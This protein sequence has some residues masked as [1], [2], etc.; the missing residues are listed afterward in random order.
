ML[1]TA[2]TSLEAQEMNFTRRLIKNCLVKSHFWK[3]SVLMKKTDC[4]RVVYGLSYFK[5]CVLLSARYP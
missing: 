3:L 2:E 5:P 1:L 4:R